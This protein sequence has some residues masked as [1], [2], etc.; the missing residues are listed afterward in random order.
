MQVPVYLTTILELFYPFILIMILEC[1]L[2]YMSWI[3]A[4]VALGLPSDPPL[5]Y[6]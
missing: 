4:I 5:S 3:D 1:A 2:G 6:G